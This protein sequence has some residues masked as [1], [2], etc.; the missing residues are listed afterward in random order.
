MFVQNPQFYLTFYFFVSEDKI[1]NYTNIAI[2]WVV[3]IHLSE[4]N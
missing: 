2:D 3:T 4:Q 1:F